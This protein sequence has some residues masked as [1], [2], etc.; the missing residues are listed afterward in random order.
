MGL[1]H[2][3]LF[4]F[5]CPRCGTHLERWQTKALG[6]E[7][8]RWR[9]GDGVDIPGLVLERA[10]VRVYKS[11]RTCGL[12]FHAWAVIEDGRFVGVEDVSARPLRAQA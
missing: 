6:C 1:F 12:W 2:E 7:L 3:F 4:D 11:C 8:A 9:V 10:R 5:T